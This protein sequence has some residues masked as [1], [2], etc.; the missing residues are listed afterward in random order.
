MAAQ[1]EADENE[2]RYQR[3]QAD[4][5][6]LQR[7]L[8]PSHL[9]VLPR[10]ALAAHYL[11]A[12]ADQAAGGDWFDALQ[13]PDDRLALVVGDVVGH[14]IEA[15]AAMGQ[16]RAVLRELLSATPDLAAA[17]ARLDAFA[18]AV[19][20]VRAA[21]VCIVVLDQLTGDLRYATMGHPPPLVLGGPDGGRYLVPT[22]SGPLGTSAAAPVVAGDRLAPRELLL[23]FS[24]GL[25]ERPGRTA[26]EGLA[27]LHRL[28]TASL[29]PTGCC[30]PAPRRR[31]S[32]GCASSASR[33]SPA[34]A[35]PTT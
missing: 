7:T 33:C 27:E 34:P 30:R 23:L 18:A 17:L 1:A 24:D 35:T 16:V 14:G 12:A 31:P 22:G 3:A 9:P 15:S 11:V 20:A 8:L 26:T 25:I 21:T 28:A 5:A 6:T 13:L 29:G 32:T 4:V 19:P 2:Q 10:T